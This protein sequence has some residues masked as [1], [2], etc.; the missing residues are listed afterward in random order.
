MGLLFAV[1]AE[2]GVL[3]VRVT[4][5]QYHKQHTEIEDERTRTAWAREPVLHD[6][7]V[8]L[9][10]DPTKSL[11]LTGTDPDAPGVL[12]AV[13]VS[14][15]VPVTPA[16]PG[17]RYLGICAHGVRLKSAEILLAEILLIAGQTLF[18]RHGAA[19]DPYLTL[20]GYFNATRELAGMRRYLD[21][22]V[23]AYL[24]D[25]ADGYACHAAL[26]RIESVWSGPSS[27]SVPVRS[28]AQVL[29]ELI[30][31]AVGELV[32]TTYAA[33]PHPPVLD[34]LD[35]ARARGV[36][37]SVVG[38]GRDPAR[39]GRRAGRNR[40]GRGVPHRC[41]DR[42]V[43]LAAGRP[44]RVGREDARQSGDR[45][46]EGAAGVQCEPHAIRGW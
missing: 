16:T 31:E 8:N 13:D 43:A 20:V 18:D 34:A 37:L 42:A 11:P 1:P 39:R 9:D 19:A 15:Q 41:R 46:P 10:G 27:H 24:R 38:R 36:R 29:V 17:Q 22:D 44:R 35:A 23:A 25:V 3:R 45:R 40:A 7:D 5:G 6:L 2:I 26:E 14:T 30:G 33:R 32:P 4:W 21:D 28:T 12:L